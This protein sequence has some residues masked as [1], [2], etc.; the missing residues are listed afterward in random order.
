MPPLSIARL[1]AA[2]AAV[3]A[4]LV[5]LDDLLV[6]WGASAVLR[7]MVSTGIMALALALWPAWFVVVIPVFIPRRKRLEDPVAQQRVARILGSFARP[8]MA[9]PGIILF[10]SD[11]P[12]GLA[13]GAPARS[14]IMLSS[15]L[16][17]Q[18]NDSEVRGTLAHECG[19]VVGRH[20]MLTSGF[21]ATLYFGKTLFGALGLPL[22]LV[23]LLVYVWIVRRNEFDAD[24][25]GAAMV[26]AADM[27]Q[28]LTKFQQVHQEP[29]WMDRPWLTILSTHPG[30]GRRIQALDQDPGAPFRSTRKNCPR[31]PK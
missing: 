8:G 17:A 23:L 13:A 12:I 16:L 3:T 20:M 14:V 27:K 30:F 21:L 11:K 7:D 24:R 5:G 28:T 26:S 4:I 22:T 25:R 19:H 29:K 6:V 1:L 9:E 18:L 15:G 10:R 2:V 31:S